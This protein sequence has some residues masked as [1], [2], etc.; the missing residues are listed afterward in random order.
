MTKN[1]NFI[2]G[3][4]YFLD[5]KSNSDGEYGPLKNLIK[6]YYNKIPLE[7]VYTK[8][9]TEDEKN[10]LNRDAFRKIGI[11]PFFFNSQSE[12]DRKKDLKTFL[13][14]L[15]NKFDEDKLEDIYSYYYSLN[16][17]DIFMNQIKISNTLIN[18]FAQFEPIK[19]VNSVK[20][21]LARLK[22]DINSL[23]KRPNINYEKIEGKLKEINS[24]ILEQ[25]EIDSCSLKKYEDKGFL[26]K[27]CDNIKSWAISGS[28]PNDVVHINI[29]DK[30][31]ALLIRILSEKMKEKIIK[32]PPFFIIE[33]YSPPDFTV[34]REKIKQNFIEAIKII[35]NEQNNNTTE[36]TNNLSMWDLFR[37][38]LLFCLIICII[39]LAVHCCCKKRRAQPDQGNQE[40]ELKDLKAQPDQGNQEEEEFKDVNQPLIN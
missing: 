26:G 1:K 16:F 15:L 4:F 33:E 17:F 8:N 31:N 36:T 35:E 21:L 30:I 23:L 19:N 34:I 10:Q 25:L 5:E 11:K 24:K 9:C 32:N 22:L 14:E 7:L 27:F 20:Y 3:I 38:L 2:Y 18:I 13:N 29:S 12:H 28:I 39:C 40:E 37:F 6:Y